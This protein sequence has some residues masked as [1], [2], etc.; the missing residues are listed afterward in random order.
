MRTVKKEFKDRENGKLLFVAWL[1]VFSY[2]SSGEG[3]M[4]N[5]CH[6]EFTMPFLDIT[7]YKITDEIYESICEA[8][9]KDYNVPL[10][11]YLEDLCFTI[12]WIKGIENLYL[13]DF[14][15]KDNELNLP[16]I[17]SIIDFDSMVWED[18]ITKLT[19][20][21]GKVSVLSKE[22]N[23]YLFRTSKF[24]LEDNNDAFEM[25]KIDLSMLMGQIDENFQNIILD[26]FN[27]QDECFCFDYSH[28]LATGTAFILKDSASEMK[29][30]CAIDI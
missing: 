3:D 15:I 25:K 11:G 4:V 24:F 9:D 14:L 2:D 5:T 16:V 10:E 12:S 1:R 27:K 26:N 30:I 21:L 8:V 28:D 20:D 23:E 22:H 13:P 29:L 6:L 19:A 17:N 18:L 7:K